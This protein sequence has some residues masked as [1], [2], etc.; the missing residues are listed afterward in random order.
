MQAWRSACK[1][2]SSASGVIKTF[3]SFSTTLQRRQN[4]SIAALLESAV[5]EGSTI[6]VNGFVQS[7]RKLKKVA[8]AAIRDGSSL[9]PLQAVL[10]PEQAQSYVRQ[11]AFASTSRSWQLIIALS[12]SLEWNG[13]QPVWAMAEMCR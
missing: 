1:V 10:S 5:P 11:P 13:G 6:Q 7:V 9:Q 2:Q 4:H 3:R 12:Q 8:F